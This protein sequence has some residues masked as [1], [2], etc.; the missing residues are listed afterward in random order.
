MKEQLKQIL[1][2]KQMRYITKEYLGEK[3]YNDI[4]YKT[5]F[6]DPGHKLNEIGR[7]H[8]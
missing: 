1:Q 3:I 2:K 8:V 4:L 6:L 7:A 5:S